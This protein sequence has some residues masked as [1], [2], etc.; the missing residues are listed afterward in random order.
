MPELAKSQN[1]VE[2]AILDAEVQAATL[3]LQLQFNKNM[4][5]FQKTNANIYQQYKQLLLL[6][7]KH[8]LVNEPLQHMNVKALMLKNIL[9][10][11]R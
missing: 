2:Q 4:A 7:P 10:R 11:L 6:P 1:T 5:F 8:L 9:H 3:K